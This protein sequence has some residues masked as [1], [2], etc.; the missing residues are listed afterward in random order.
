MASDF[1]KPDKVHTLYKSEIQTKMWP[2]DIS[3]LFM[4]GR[5]STTK[6]LSRGFKTIGDI[7]RADKQILQNLMGKHGIL[8]WEYA[9]GIDNSEFE[10]ERS[11]KSIRSSETLP[12]DILTK[13]D[14]YKQILRLSEDVSKRLRDLKLCASLI[15]IEIKNTD[16][17]KY[18]HQQK[19]SSSICSSINIY[20]NAIKVFDKLYKGEAIRSIALSV[21]SLSNSKCEQISFFETSSDDKCQNL[22][23]AIDCIR[24]KYNQ[25]IIKRAS[26]L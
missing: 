10:L 25:G 5:K 23:D 18:S 2:L 19:L 9:S 3:S 17:E 13:Q 26:L 6:L 24:K 14:A 22:D 15:A 4:L 21:G 20:Q 16:F 7:A 1:E 11:A 8:L 12:F